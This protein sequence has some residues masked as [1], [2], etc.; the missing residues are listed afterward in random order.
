MSALRKVRAVGGV[1]ESV[2]AGDFVSGFSTGMK[3]T[4]AVAAAGAL[5][6]AL[7]LEGRS[8]ATERPG[9]VRRLIHLHRAQS[10]HA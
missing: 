3:I 8:P 2:P 5:T 6:A 7:T 4:A 10:P 1:L 9:Y